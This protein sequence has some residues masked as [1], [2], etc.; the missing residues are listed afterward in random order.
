MKSELFT[1]IASGASGL[2][3][4]AIREWQN[5]LKPFISIIRFEG[6]N[7]ITS[8]EV[9]IN[10]NLVDKTN[11]SFF[12]EPLDSFTPLERLHDSKEQSS[13]IE[14]VGHSIL[15]YCQEIEKVI[16]D[17]EPDLELIKS[18]TRLF[19]VE[20][21][22]TYL[23]SL[24]VMGRI[25]IFNNN[26]DGINLFDLVESQKVNN[27]CFVLSSR[28][29][30][31][32]LGQD[33]ND[34]TLNKNIFE[35]ILNALIQLNKDQINTL[36]NQIK[37]C[38]EHEIKIAKDILPE[39]KEISNEHSNWETYLYIANLKKTPLLLNSTAKL[40]V[41]DKTGASFIE[42]C[43]LSVQKTDEDGNENMFHLESPL[44]IPSGDNVYVSFFTKKTQKEMDRGRDFR[45][46]FA[47][48]EAKAWLELDMV[49]IGLLK[50]RKFATPKVIFKEINE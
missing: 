47:H 23:G 33:F 22:N 28:G 49:G 6:D 41:K 19:A 20:G 4:Y 10:K 16:R 36:S 1:L 24:I 34:D 9:E 40:Y 26:T 13:Y 11:D 42:E 48:G 2:I 45:N 21:F 39:L 25:E 35:P 44:I 3:G 50:R 37:I 5:H 15:G 14:H 31:I 17:N 38:I 8:S 43:S 18:L 7:Y 12:I 27:G 32:A 46:T 30:Y 29:F